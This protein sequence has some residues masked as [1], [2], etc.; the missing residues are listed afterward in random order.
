ME[1]KNFE[2]KHLK[3]GTIILNGRYEYVVEE[4]LGEG[5]FG[6]TYKVYADVKT[7]NITHRNYFA[8]KEYFLG[9][10]CER[11]NQTNR[12]ICS[13]PVKDKVETGMRDFIS[14]AS[15]LSR[16]AHPNVVKVNEVFEANDTAYYVMEYLEGGN[17]WKYIRNY[18]PMSP[19]EMLEVINPIIDAVAY[20]LWALALK[21]VGNTAKIANLAYL[22][23]FLSLV[24][25]AIVIGEKIR[26]QAV[27]A[28]VFIIGGILLQSFFKS[29]K[30][31]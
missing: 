22:T 26:F 8:I 27:I 1:K 13:N 16:L 31:A 2:D 18:G 4:V 17:L 6:I 23:P 30:K 19:A 15:R 25:S 12:M 20:L 28:L 21:G 11:E 10:S 29:G 24:I 5:G 9:D 3:P 14:E 7:G